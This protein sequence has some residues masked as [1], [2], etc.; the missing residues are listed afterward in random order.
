MSARKTERLLNLVICLLAARQYVPKEKIRTTVA[1]YSDCRTDEAFE[2][3]F[4]RDKDELREMGVPLETGTNSAWFDDEPGYRIPPGEY[5]LPE[6]ALEPDEAAALGLAA[7][8]WQQATLARA[9]S[10]ALLKLQAAGVQTADVSLAGIEPRVSA[11]EPAFEP[12]W[13][14][15]CDRR[16]VRFSYRAAQSPQVL[17]RRLEPW[18]IV[19]WHGHWYA[20]GHDLDRDAVRVFRLDRVV[21]AVRPFGTPGSVVVPAGVDIRAQ[22]VGRGS[23]PADRTLARVR[24]RAGAG[25][26]LRRQ[27]ATVKPDND[28][29]DVVELPYWD[30]EGLG[31]WLAGFGGD[32]VALDPPQLRDAVLRRVRAVAAGELTE[33]RHPLDQG[34]RQDHDPDQDAEQSRG[35]AT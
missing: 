11:S 34:H 33:R 8:T 4:E 13:R 15:V 9:A 10:D 24:I 23:A 29:W 26:P 5:G 31:E 1:G 6:I 19:S 2:R 3:M 21:G 18:G 32:V 25:F 16:P 30:A 12:L 20:V 35:G 22:V 7:R 17:E 14:A 27:A 28:G